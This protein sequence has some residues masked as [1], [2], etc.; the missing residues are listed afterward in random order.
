LVPAKFKTHDE[1][2]KTGYLVAESFEGEK[3]LG[4]LQLI[5]IISL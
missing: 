3:V 2:I 1:K 5:D 4:K